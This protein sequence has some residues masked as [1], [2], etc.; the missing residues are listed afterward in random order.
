MNL[1]EIF[2]KIHVCMERGYMKIYVY[3]FFK[4]GIL[5]FHKW[6][7]LLKYNVL[8]A[9]ASIDKKLSKITKTASKYFIFGGDDPKAEW[10]QVVS[11][12]INNSMGMCIEINNRVSKGI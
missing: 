5:I 7:K 6:L 2:V 3:N 12:D 8:P 11:A 4:T 9:A 10:N 1:I